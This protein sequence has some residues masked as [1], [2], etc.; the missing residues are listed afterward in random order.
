MATASPPRRPK[1][2]AAP[3]RPKAI[4]NLQDAQHHQYKNW[5]VYGQSGVGKSALAGTAP[6]ALLLTAESE[7]SASAK[8][9]GSKADELKLT[10]W[11]EFREAV[12]WLEAEGHKEY[13]WV[14]PDGI[15]ELEEHA[16]NAIMAQ[17]KLP[18]SV[19]GGFRQRSR[20]DYPLVW[21]AMYNEID[22]LNRMPVNVLYTAQ[23]M[24]VDVET[25]EGE[26]TTLALPLVGSTKRGDLAMKICGQMTLVGYYRH[27]R[28][29]ET[30]K[31]IRRLHTMDG[32]RW[33]AK[34]R[35]DAFGAYV[36]G[37]NIATMVAAVEERLAAPGRRTATK[38]RRTSTARTKE[39]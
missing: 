5:L 24:R 33:V 30:G 7:G 34:D 21:S 35:H 20:N 2:T 38:K 18:R 22:R 14:C 27:I 28:N 1:R 37:P 17:G 12:A 11:Q 16:W 31:R 9:L 36:D 25:D 15:T 13:D 26:D 3:K 39:Q 8:A 19:G 10:S 32:E 6:K 23:T 4:V 29:D